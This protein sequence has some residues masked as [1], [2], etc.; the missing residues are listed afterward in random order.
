MRCSSTSNRCGS[1]SRPTPPATGVVVHAEPPLDVVTLGAPPAARAATA[2]D[3]RLRAAPAIDDR[4]DRA[5]DRRSP[6]RY[7]LGCGERDW[8]IA[9]LDHPHYVHAMFETYFRAA[10]GRFAGGLDERRAP[11]GASPF[12]VLE[13]PP[14]YDIVRD[15]NKLSNNVMARQIFLTLATTSRRRRPRRRRRRADAVRRWLAARKLVDAGARARER[16]GIVA[17][18]AQ[19]RR[20][21]STGC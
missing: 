2:D 14:L 8:W 18:R 10:G 17:T 7:P 20:S 9:M 19:H 6:A 5:R 12:A 11:A 15:V 16:L 21:G 1:R 3:W 4:G 13:S